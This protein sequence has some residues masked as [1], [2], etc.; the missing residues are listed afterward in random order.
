MTLVRVDLE[1]PV[2]SVTLDRPAKLNALSQ[3][4]LEELIDVATALRAHDELKVVVIAGEGR[5]FCAGFDLA[6]VAA[7]DPARPPEGRADLGRQCADALDRIPAVTIASI[8]GHCVGGGVVLASACDLRYAASDTRFVIPEVELGIPLTWGGVPRLVRELGPA[9]ARELVM[10]ARPFD[11]M[12][13]ERFGF[14]NRAVPAAELAAAVR[15]VVACLTALPA[16]ALRATKQQVAIAADQ[17]ASTR[18]ADA[19]AVLLAAAM[20]DPECRARSRDYLGRRG[21]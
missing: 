20:R 1:G 2:A 13:A 21:G 6:E 9:R 18:H 10:T 16:L 3:A 7:N 15:D 4:L 8:H 17:L 12:E 5:A 11:G 19:E 14:V